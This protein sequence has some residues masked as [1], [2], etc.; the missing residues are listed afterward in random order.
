MYYFRD[1][2]YDALG[3]KA[4]I[5]A[6]ADDARLAT[7]VHGFRRRPDVLERALRKNKRA[8]SVGVTRAY[9]SLCIVGAAK[10][11]RVFRLDG[12]FDP[13]AALVV[14]S[15]MRWTMP[16]GVFRSLIDGAS[17]RARGTAG[18]LLFEE[19]GADY[20][21]VTESG[22]FC[23]AS[24]FGKLCESSGRT[25]VEKWVTAHADRVTRAVL[26]TGLQSSVEAGEGKQPRVTS[27]V[28][29]LLDEDDAV[30]LPL[31]PR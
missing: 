22:A 3:I 28:Q 15:S 31:P 8:T 20:A 12:R 7:M 5:L 27:Y 9:L 18:A 17:S 29:S 1:M 2:L 10:A 6:K 23:A 13:D 11:A 16:H 4:R 30:F 21:A 14:A 25:V 19:Y 24:C 26:E